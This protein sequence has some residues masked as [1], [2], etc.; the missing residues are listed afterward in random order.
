MSGK[1]NVLVVEKDLSI[2]GFTAEDDPYHLRLQPP[3][4]QHRI[5]TDAVDDLIELVL[6]KNGEVRFVGNGMLARFNGIAMINRY[7]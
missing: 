6:E 2:P 3:T 5:L 7:V 1:G 4:G